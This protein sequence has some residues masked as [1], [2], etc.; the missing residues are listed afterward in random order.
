MS[1]ALD[2]WEQADE[3]DIQAPTFILKPSKEIVVTPNFGSAAAA[4]AAAGGASSASGATGKA[5][6]TILRRN[7][8]QKSGMK[9][10]NDG[11]DNN[12]DDDLLRTSEMVG[13]GSSRLLH[14]QNCSLWEKANAYEQ[15]IITRND[16]NSMR[17]EYVPEIRILRRP[18]SPIQTTAKV[19][20]TIPKTLA[21][22]EADYMAAREKIFGSSSST[23]AT[24]SSDSISTTPTTNARSS[25]APRSG[26]SPPL[27]MVASVHR[28][29]SSGRFSDSEAA[30]V[31]RIEFRGAPPSLRLAQRPPSWGGQGNIIRQPQGPLNVSSAS[32]SSS[33]SSLGSSSPGQARGNG[34]GGSQDCSGS[35]GFRKGFR[36]R[37][38]PQ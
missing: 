4:A 31:K 2:D 10:G 34:I 17:T 28:Q 26:S 7:H 15:P 11:D 14:E 35:I 25:P 38:P 22:R 21:Q 36:P 32:S 5:P 29:E 33:S 13:P 30:D 24:S 1:D 3:D 18:K 12:G 37:P 19:N 9:R 16:Q 6:I 27:S 20:Q 23:T 8:E